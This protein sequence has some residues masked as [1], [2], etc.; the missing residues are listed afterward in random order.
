LVVVAVGGLIQWAKICGERTRDPDEMS[1]RKP[2]FVRERSGW[3]GTRKTA[4]EI[5]VG[6]VV[7]GV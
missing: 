7:I 6:V 1:D 2:E 4:D 3:R 5:Y